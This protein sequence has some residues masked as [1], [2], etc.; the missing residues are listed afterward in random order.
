[1]KLYS[2]SA[3]RNKEIIADAFHRLLP[4]AAHV[5]ELASGTGEHA[6]A[7]LAAR[8]RL[9]WQASDPDEEARASVSARMGE[10]GQAPAMS[11]DTR[12]N[13]WWK[14]IREPID[15]VVSIN[16]IHITSWV[17][18]E[19]LFQGMGALLGD[20]GHLFLYGP[21]KRQGLTEESNQQFDQSLKLR[22]P[23]WG[24][25]DL[26]DE[27]QPLAARFGL[28]LSHAERVPA[29][30]HIVLFKKVVHGEN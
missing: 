3:A 1:M 23:S 21:M 27:L 7:I 2:T 29:N 4:S 20:G 17:G 18:V 5:L 15:T 13:R 30:N 10:L 16:M 26:D 19:G 12:T 22:D 6:E 8:P 11:F 25:R 14:D 24:V 9:G 28:S